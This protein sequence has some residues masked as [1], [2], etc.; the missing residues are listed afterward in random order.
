MQVH[1]IN[2][3]SKLPIIV[4]L[5]ITRDEVFRY[6]AGELI[7]NVWPKMTP[8]EREFYL[9]GIP[10]GLFEIQFEK[11]FVCII[12]GLFVRYEIYFAKSL[13]DFVVY[14]FIDNVFQLTEKLKWKVID[15]KIELEVNKIDGFLLQTFNEKIN[16]NQSLIEFCS[17]IQD[18]KTPKYSDYDVIDILNK[19]S[20]FMCKSYNIEFNFDEFK[21]ANNVWYGGFLLQKEKEK[22]EQ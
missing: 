9:S 12:D 13:K 7:Q 17:K 14:K 4:D 15:N 19:Y 22:S 8:D 6:S 20:E 5:D 21:H 3:L 1:R 10:M 2:P 11:H 18:T 16:E